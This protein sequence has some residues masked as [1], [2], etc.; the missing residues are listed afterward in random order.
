[1]LDRFSSESVECCWFSC[2]H[3][4]L[5]QPQSQQTQ[6]FEWS[7]PQFLYYTKL[8]TSLWHS[9]N[10]T[11]ENG[12]TP[13]ARTGKRQD[14]ITVSLPPLMFHARNVGRSVCVFLSA[15]YTTTTAGCLGNKDNN[16]K[17]KKW[18]R[19]PLLHMTSFLSLKMKTYTGTLLPS[20]LTG[21]SRLFIFYFLVNKKI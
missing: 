18:Q 6:R 2:L 8:Q 16:L 20:N 7:L 9:C 12:I 10:N 17:Q 14:D 21:Q 11:Q 4:Q 19:G 3:S 1:M 15:H 5:G 13:H